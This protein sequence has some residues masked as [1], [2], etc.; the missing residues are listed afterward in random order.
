MSDFKRLGVALVERYGS[1]DAERIMA[2]NALSPAPE[3]RV[4]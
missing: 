4:S 3:G 1:E 2:G